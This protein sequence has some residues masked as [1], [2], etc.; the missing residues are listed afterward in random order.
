MIMRIFFCVYKQCVIYIDESIDGMYYDCGCD[1]FAMGVVLFILM[2]GYPPFKSAD[3]EDK[4]YKYIAKRDYQ[5][6][7][8]A[9]RDSRLKKSETNLITRMLLCDK[10]YINS[11]EH[12]L[13][14]E[15]E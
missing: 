6:F 12:A 15:N 14:L 10:E 8:R 1:I 5:S 2:T 3:G 9:H 13:E 4:W 11:F 7:W